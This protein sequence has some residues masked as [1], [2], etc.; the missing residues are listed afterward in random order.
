MP[1]KL[2]DL[3]QEMGRAGRKGGRAYW[4]LYLSLPVLNQTLGLA[5][6]VSGGAAT[7]E[8]RVQ[9]NLDAVQHVLS[10]LLLPGC[11]RSRLYAGMIGPAPCPACLSCDRCCRSLRATQALAQTA[12]FDLTPAAGALCLELQN[13]RKPCTPSEAAKLTHLPHPF[14]RYHQRCVLLYLLLAH[15][16]ARLQAPGDRG[17]ATLRADQEA[18]NQASLCSAQV[19]LAAVS[20]WLASPASSVAALRGEVEALYAA[21]ADCSTKL[22]QVERERES[23]RLLLREKQVALAR[24]ERRLAALAAPALDEVDATSRRLSS[25]FSAVHDHEPMDCDEDSE[26]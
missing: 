20:P 3:L 26:L 1:P 17:R 8:H 4:L 2:S 12:P 18:A 21:E 9:Q 16:S 19:P 6:R 24:E 7:E 25:M 13:A 14:T 11:R 22:Q 23:V 10:A 5:C 15:K